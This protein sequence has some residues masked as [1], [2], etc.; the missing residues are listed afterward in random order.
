MPRNIQEIG[1]LLDD[2]LWMVSQVFLKQ[3]EHLLSRKLVLVTADLFG[4][5]SR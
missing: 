5:A 3:D 4:E 2:A 1:Y